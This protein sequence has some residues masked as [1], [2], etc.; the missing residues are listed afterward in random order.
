MDIWT[1]TNHDIGDDQK[2][3]NSSDY[4]MGHMYKRCWGNSSKKRSRAKRILCLGHKLF[5]NKLLLATLSCLERQRQRRADIKE[6]QLRVVGLKC[7][8]RT[9]DANGAEETIS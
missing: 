8:F 9:S 3:W 4:E 2:S 6:F 5:W 7:G 1:T